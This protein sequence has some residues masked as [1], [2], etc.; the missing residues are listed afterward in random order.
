M[1]ARRRW[2]H[3]WADVMH[4]ACKRSVPL[5]PPRR[6]VLH[7]RRKSLP[8]P[9]LRPAPHACSFAKGKTV[10]SSVRT[11]LT[12]TITLSTEAGFSLD[13]KSIVSVDVKETFTMETQKTTEQAQDGESGGCYRA[14]RERGIWGFGG[15]LE[16]LKPKSACILHGR[17]NASPRV[18]AC[19]RRQTGKGG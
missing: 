8:P 17:M 16:G 3:A 2:A 13:I 19:P 4:V 7:R 6:S 15:G 12:D 11:S 18:H 10:T 5:P 9:C 14:G 1:S